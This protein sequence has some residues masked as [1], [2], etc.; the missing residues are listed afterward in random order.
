MGGKKPIDI[1]LKIKESNDELVQSIMLSRQEIF[2]KS[3][4]PA[5]DVTI[6]VPEMLVKSRMV[7]RFKNKKPPA[8][9]L[10]KSGQMVIQVQI[11][12][13]KFLAQPAFEFSGDKIQFEMDCEFFKLQRR[14]DFRMRLPKS[15][16]SRIV[17]KKKNS[18]PVSFDAG[19]VDISS[20]GCR[21]ES[22]KQA[23]SLKNGD[24]VEGEIQFED[25]PTVAVTG[26][27]R[28]LGPLPDDN[29]IE[30]VG[31]Q[32]A[33][34]TAYSKNKIFSLIMDIYKELF[35]KMK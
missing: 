20:G 9:S 24:R 29:N 33:D 22:N 5:E 34:L 10:P 23:L 17:F 1:F 26:I 2:A 11:G 18:T 8:F 30:F 25:R 19:L 3:P 27:V 7:C 16:K 15:F 6:L 13:E 31:L 14:E 4:D 21:F 32:F 28:H 12:D 35:N